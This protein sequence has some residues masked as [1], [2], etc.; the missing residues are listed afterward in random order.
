MGE[1]TERRSGWCLRCL[2]WAL[3]P[4]LGLALL[5]WWVIEQH[6]GNEH[7]AQDHKAHAVAQIEADWQAKWAGAQAEINE[8]KAKLAAT[9]TAP[10]PAPNLAAE[11]EAEMKALRIRISELENSNRDL[12]DQLRKA[13]AD[14]LAASSEAQQRIAAVR[15]GLMGR[16]REKLANEAT[17]GSDGLRGFA[18]SSKVAFKV[19]DS[20][21]SDEGKAAIDKIIAEVKE[22]LAKNPDA[23]WVLVVKGHTD[24]RPINTER[25][26]S[27]WEL[28]ASRAASVVRYMIENGVPEN[29]LVAVG[30]AASE[31]LD[32]GDTEEAHAKNRRI[33]F[34]LEVSGI[35]N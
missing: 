19:S 8:L 15:D 1:H 32:N 20:A 11:A 22:E 2:L 24:K 30:K 25:F 6:K 18:L 29:R 31:L 12:G 4:L 3:L 27:N 17:A 23:P 21:L 14:L 5:T 9:P 33:E 26:P 7:G 28:S 35:K 13:N 34:D 16:L 10:A